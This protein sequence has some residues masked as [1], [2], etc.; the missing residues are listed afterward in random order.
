MAGLLFLAT[1]HYSM[2]GVSTT[3][4]NNAL[5]ESAMR[6]TYKICHEIAKELKTFNE[7][8]FDRNFGGHL[9]QA[10]RLSATS[11]PVP[12]LMNTNTYEPR[13]GEAATTPRLLGGAGIRGNSYRSVTHGLRASRRGK[14]CLRILSTCMKCRSGKSEVQT[15]RNMFYKSTQI[16]AFADDIVIIDR[17]L[18]Y[19][20]EVFLSL[21]QAGKEI[22]LTVNERKTKYMLADNGKVQHTPL[23]DGVE[24][25]ARIGRLLY[26]IG[27]DGDN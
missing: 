2:P 22:G 26:K 9:C 27:T 19:V 1:Y 6:I 5:S 20:K 4:D 7:D 25:D 21:E 10:L 18:K 24:E 3:D 12:S 17:S 16:L 14:K 8:V 23:I 15:R 13:F 11:A